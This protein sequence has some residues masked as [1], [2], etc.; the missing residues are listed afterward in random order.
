MVRYRPA[1][2]YAFHPCDDT[3]PPLHEF[4]GKNREMQAEKQLMMQEIVRGMDELGVLLM[5]HARGAYWYGSTLTI[6]EARRVA[7]HPGEPAGAHSDWTPLLDR[8]RLFAEDVDS[9]DPWQF[10]NF[11]VS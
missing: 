3:V 10:H 5:N 11:R 1:V 4:A 2:H 6:K 8:S 9:I 7:P